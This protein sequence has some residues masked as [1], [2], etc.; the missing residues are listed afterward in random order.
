MFRTV[1]QPLVLL[2]ATVLL[3]VAAGLVLDGSVVEAARSIPPV[4]RSRLYGLT[5][6]GEGV[7]ILVIAAVLFALAAYRSA[8][9]P[10]RRLRV[11]WSAAAGAAGYVFVATALAGLLASLV[12]NSVGRARPSLSEAEGILSLHP[13]AFD[14]AYASWPSGHA[15]TCGAAA[16]ALALVFPR[17]RFPILGIGIGIAATRAGIRAHYVSDVIAGLGLGAAVSLGLAG[18]LARRAWVFRAA[19]GAPP[20]L[21]RPRRA[22]R[23][24]P[25]DAVATLVG[26]SRQLVRRLRGPGRATRTGS[27]GPG[28]A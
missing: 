1:S 15:A 26:A 7:E 28:P 10:E 13:F 20:A 11:A 17:W 4:W 18:A 14:S 9:A 22:A 5:R 8:H 19:A 2:A 16:V 12:K 25:R 24:L 3:S 27:T 23:H 6:F 21:R